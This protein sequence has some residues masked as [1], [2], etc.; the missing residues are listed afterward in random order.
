LSEIPKFSS[1]DIKGWL[2]SET[3]S[4]F[5]PVHTRAEKL[6]NDMNK[7]IE[8]ISDVSKVLL[9]NSSKEI[10]KRNMKTYGRARALNKLARL[11]LDRMRHIKVPD[12]VSYDDF[13][14]FDQETQK[15]FFAI[16]V[17]IRNWFPRISPYFI[18]DRRRFLMIFEKAKALLKEFNDF[19][20]KEYV[21]TKTL[22]ETFQLIDRLQTLETQL[23]SLDKQRRK[24]GSEKAQITEEI[25]ETQQKMAD[26]KSKGSISRL[27]Q[28][29]AEI[30]ILRMETKRSL[31]HLRKPFIKL[32]SLALHG[33]G[34]G[35]T[36]DELRKLNRYLENP[37]ETLAEE[38]ADYP[39]LR[40]ILQKLDR[41]I[42][43]GKLKLKP[44]KERKA[45][46][47][48]ENILNGNSFANLHRKCADAMERKKKLSTSAD[49]AETR[50]DLSR[51]Q[52]FLENL[53]RRKGVAEAEENAVSRACSETQRK[54]RNH[55]TAIERNVLSFI[56]KRILIE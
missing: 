27:N 5:V 14:D 46:Q 48:M 35:L 10:E 33:R 30:E 18:L 53:E 20:T 38:E 2:E 43:E 52:E 15:A 3:K 54:I 25:A 24:V 28:I 16:E 51:L 40:Q 19:L 7:M 50:S 8:D 13:R 1:S 21:K 36:P 12:R 29:G 11:F 56:D 22:E 55:K 17:D 39:V 44:D 31:Q 34:S 47:A 9:D 6:L 45:K 37:F 41:S 4:V 23:T 42:S 32:T 26:L 49:V